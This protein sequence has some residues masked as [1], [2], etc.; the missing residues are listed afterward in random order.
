[1]DQTVSILIVD[2]EAANLTALEA[3]LESPEYRLVRAQTADEA[4]MAVMQSDYAAIVLDIQMPDMSGIE[5][6]RLIKKRKRFE[7][8]PILF[9]TAYYQEEEHIVL[10]YG[11]G[12]VDYLTKPV[13]PAVLRSK[14]AVF[15]DLFCKTQALARLNRA[16]VGEIGERE[17]AEEALRVANAE[18][19]AKNAELLHR[20]S[21]RDLR[22][23]AEAAQE[24]S[25]LLAEASSILAR[26]F[27]TEQTFPE[28]ASLAVARL[29]DCCFIDTAEDSSSDLLAK[30]FR[31]DSQQEEFW[32]AVLAR[33]EREAGLATVI[34]SRRS[35]VGDANTSPLESP[36]GADAT[37]HIQSWIIAPMRARGRMLGTFSLFSSEPSRFK[38]AE[39]SLVEEL[40]ERAGIAL[41]NSRLFTE[42]KQAREAAEAANTAKDR[43]LAMLSHELRTPLSPVLHAVALLREDGDCPPALRDSLEIIHR[44]VQLEARLIDDLLDLARIRNG[45]LQL[46]EEPSDAHDLLQRALGICQP[47]IEAAN[48]NLALNL[49]A[50]Q[51]ILFAD[52]ARIQQ[53]FWNVL[54]NA[55]K[56]TQSGGTISVETA[57]QSGQLM[58]QIKDTGRGIDPARL[59]T[60]FDAF[61]QADSVNSGGLGLGLAICKAL[62]I[63]HGG[64]IAVHSEGIGFGTTFAISL[65]VASPERLTSTVKPAASIPKPRRDLRLLL[66]EDHP[67]SATT[68][69][70]LLSRRGYEVRL[71]S[72]VSGALKIAQEF[73]FDLLVSD[74]GLP[75]GTGIDLVQTLSNLRKDREIRAVALSGYGRQQDLESSRAAGFQYHLTKPVDFPLLEDALTRLGD[76]SFAGE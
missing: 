57:N 7:H 73:D 60:I 65:P 42:A 9:L 71:A 53:I 41:D 17:K 22:I 43:F 64:S 20:V 63:A 69:Q 76:P 4:L 13:N 5:L 26:S 31:E 24:R 46:R 39:I 25:S 23:R 27:D 67:D 66:V 6:A 54:S 35:F 36:V 44:N 50:A 45:K 16:L 48:L 61:E 18:L 12:A 19:A 37:P 75:D 1:M 21:E 68:L 55:I 33:P 29:A 62:T 47:A 15:V 3:I 72:S 28:L 34:N 30:A 49:K 51:S 58:V 59:E 2:D 56:H 10:G 40:A 14:I 70:R 32:E 38:Q 74:I 8:I 11:A 52:P